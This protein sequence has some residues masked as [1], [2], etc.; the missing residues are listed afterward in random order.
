MGLGQVGKAKGLKEMK[1]EWAVLAGAGLI[2]AAVLVS[3]H[4]QMQVV[5]GSGLFR[6]NRW[7]GEAT[8]CETHK[9]PAD[10]PDGK[11]VSICE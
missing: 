1:L 10:L 3:N 6:L 9:E 2:S 11:F 7:T 8:I 4:W 5:S